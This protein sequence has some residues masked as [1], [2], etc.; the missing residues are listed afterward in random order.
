MNDQLQSGALH[1]NLNARLSEVKCRSSIV[2]KCI[3]KV[4]VVH[5]RL[6]SDHNHKSVLRIL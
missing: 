2:Q 6:S 5:S 3:N 1:S 4:K